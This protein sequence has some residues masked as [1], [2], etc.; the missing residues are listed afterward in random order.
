MPNIIPATLISGRGYGTSDYVFFLSKIAMNRSNII[1]EKLQQ[2]MQAAILTF[3]H[4]EIFLTKLTNIFSA[5]WKLVF[6]FAI[7]NSHPS[8][9]QFHT[10]RILKTPPVI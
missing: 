8:I 3:C 9:Y 1:L 6:D 2:M 10:S 7:R 4:F 5:L